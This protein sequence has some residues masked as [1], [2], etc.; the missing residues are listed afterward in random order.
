MNALALQEKSIVIIGGTSGL[1]LSAALACLAE[2]ARLVVMGRDDEFAPLARSQLGTDV[3]LLLGDACDPRAAEA[4][5]EQ[6]VGQFGRLD[7]LYHVAGGSGRRWGDGP[8]DT[9]DDNAFRRVLELN[10]D[11]VL[12]SNRAAARQFLRQET[13]G[14]VLNL[15]SVLAASPAPEHFAT[16]AYAAAKAGLVGLTR[17]AAAYYA[18]RRIRFNVLAAGLIETPQS[19]RATS[20][21][22]IRSYLAARQPLATG[23]VGDT[24]DLDAAVVYFL[25]DTSRLVTG[26][27]LSI[28]AGWQLGGAASN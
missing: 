19:A 14:S 6:A 15:G 12:Y 3:C 9:I 13:G 16:H 23:G 8:L 2:G 22:N 5:I 18:T 7:G 11:S 28:D 10:L 17:A 20:D 27:V 25:S 21:P 1:G 26:Q 24:T 4:A